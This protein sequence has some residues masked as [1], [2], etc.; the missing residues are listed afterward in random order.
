MCEEAS[1]RAAPV[2]SFLASLLNVC[3]PRTNPHPWCR[4]LEHEIMTV[5]ELPASDS[6][7]AKESKAFA[8][9]A[10]SYGD[11]NDLGSQTK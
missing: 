9:F 7:S 10:S 5:D 1:K 2:A 4:N 8:A 6:A 3:Q 11:E